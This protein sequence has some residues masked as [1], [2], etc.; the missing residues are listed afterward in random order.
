MGYTIGSGKN[1]PDQLTYIKIMQ[2]NLSK[3]YET[4]INTKSQYTKL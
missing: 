4:S 3:M 2:Q 1:N